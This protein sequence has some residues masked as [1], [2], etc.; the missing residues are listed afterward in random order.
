MTCRRHTSCV[1]S[2]KVETVCLAPQGHLIH[3][4]TPV[5]NLL[6][7]LCIPDRQ[8]RDVCSNVS[9][10]TKRPSDHAAVAVA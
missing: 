6:S 9:L 10:P 4:D 3:Q 8:V 5:E 1:V 2:T 7:P